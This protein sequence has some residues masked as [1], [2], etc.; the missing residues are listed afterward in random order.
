MEITVTEKIKLILSRRG[1]TIGDLA[2]ATGQSRQ[3]LSNKMR[4]DNYTMRELRQ[5]ADAM[6][7]DVDVVFTMPDGS[8]FGTTL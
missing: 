4:R 5:L 8:T 6:Q 3:N 7:C 1:M 2:A